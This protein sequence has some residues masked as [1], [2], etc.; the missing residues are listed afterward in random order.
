M[1]PKGWKLVNTSNAKTCQ[2]KNAKGVTRTWYWCEK[3]CHDQ[4]CW[5]PRE[6]CRSKAE[7]KQFMAEKKKTDGEPFSAPPSNKDT[8]KTNEDF[9][10][11]LC[12]MV[13]EQDMKTLEEQ[14]F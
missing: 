6:T 7:Y 10:I 5:C 14:F 9:K 8:I 4:P 12:S 2:Q 11:A 13:S 1:P 3:D